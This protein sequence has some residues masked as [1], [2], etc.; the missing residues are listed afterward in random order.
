MLAS[1]RASANG[2]L[3]A[4]ASIALGRWAGGCARID[5][6]RSTPVTDRSTGPWDPAPAP[7]LSALRASPRCMPGLTSR[8]RR[9]ADGWTAGNGSE[10]LYLMREVAMARLG[11]GTAHRIKAFDGR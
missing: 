8:T 9:H 4:V 10:H 6:D 2:R 1:K 7:P 5:A 11:V 3:P